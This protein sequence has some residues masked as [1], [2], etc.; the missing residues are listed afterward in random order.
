VSVRQL[1]APPFSLLKMD[2]GTI[3]RGVANQGE[4]DRV[5][6]WVSVKQGADLLPPEPAVQTIPVTAQG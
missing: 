4:S 6:F 3:H 2:F 5:M 1:L